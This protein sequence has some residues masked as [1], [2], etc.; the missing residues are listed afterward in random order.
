MIYITKYIEI[1]GISHFDERS[2]ECYSMIRDGTAP[3]HSQDDSA[4]SYGI[5][6]SLNNTCTKCCNRDCEKGF[7]H[8]DKIYHQKFIPAQKNTCWDCNTLRRY[9]AKPK[10]FRT[11]GHCVLFVLFVFT[12]FGI[13]YG[14]STR[15]N[16]TL[17][18]E[19][20]NEIELGG[21]S[22][23]Q[24]ESHLS[25]GVSLEQFRTL[26]RKAKSFRDIYRMFIQKKNVTDDQID[27]ILTT[28]TFKGTIRKKEINY[29]YDYD[30]PVNPIDADVQRVA[31]EAFLHYLAVKEH[32]LG[33]CN[34]PTPELHHIPPEGNKLY[35]PEYT[36]LHV[37]RNV[38]GCC[39]NPSQECGEKDIEIITKSFIVAEIQHSYKGDEVYIPDSNKVEVK[40]F[41]NV[42]RCGCKD[43]KPLPK[44]DKHCPFPFTKKRPGVECVCDCNDDTLQCLK[45]KF[46][47]DPLSSGDF[48][49]VKSGRC[50][51]PLCNSGT[52]DMRKGYCEGTP[53]PMLHVHLSYRRSKRRAIN[54]SHRKQY[55]K[56]RFIQERHRKR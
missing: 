11:L 54:S 16:K 46:G 23:F 52:F 24:V 47:I 4:I 1:F 26:S 38:S 8:I 19:G 55:T 14:N 27:K 10:M 42:T 3:Q 5:Y 53:N 43:L 44:C 15:Q 21:P 41:K 37:C 34:D 29:D 31:D 48:E 40:F 39:W 12:C 28:R 22:K 32:P 50:M 17:I 35:F 49:C 18:G 25:R 13:L 6:S 51:K 56:F 2:T 20:E 30:D 36:I 7:I 45:I 33:S 9:S